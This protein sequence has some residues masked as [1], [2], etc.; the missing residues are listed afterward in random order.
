MVDI[1]CAY[2][3]PPQTHSTLMSP[4]NARYY[5]F[6]GRNVA[7][8]SSAEL[9]II[10]SIMCQNNLRRKILGLRK[11]PGWPVNLGQQCWTCYARYE[12]TRSSLFTLR[13]PHLAPTNNQT[14]LTR[15]TFACHGKS[16]VSCFCSCSS[17][18]HQNRRSSI[19]INISRIY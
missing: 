3:T 14:Q 6:L 17:P 12:H 1:I 11:A 16:S 2:N 13:P 19:Y 18:K 9:I 5:L 10:R 7:D 15:Q 8:S 4:G